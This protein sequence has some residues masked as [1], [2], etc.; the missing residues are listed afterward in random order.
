[1]TLKDIVNDYRCPLVNSLITE[2]GE[3]YVLERTGMDIR[4]L[5]KSSLGSYFEYNASDWVCEFDIVCSCETEK[6]K[7]YGGEGSY[8]SD[9]MAYAVDKETNSPVWLLFLDS[10]NPIVNIR[11]DNGIVYAYNNNGECLIVP[12]TEPLE[13]MRLIKCDE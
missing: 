11:A 10:L 1:M 8:G 9:G 5:C 13:N 2:G 6:Y 12:L 7:I 3:L 4:V